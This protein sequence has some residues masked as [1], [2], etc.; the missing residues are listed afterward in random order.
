MP[1]AAAN[2]SLVLSSL[3]FFKL[4]TRWLCNAL[5][6]CVQ[7]IP[8]VQISMQG[9]FAASHKAAGDCLLIT[10]GKIMEAIEK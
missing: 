4:S 9:K 2:K 1:L 7:G 3:S 5:F 8:S 10:E 6:L